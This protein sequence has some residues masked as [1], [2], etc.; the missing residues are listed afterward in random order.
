MILKGTIPCEICSAEMVEKTSGRGYV[1][2][3]CKRGCSSYRTMD[4][5]TGLL[6]ATKKA[7]QTAEILPIRP[8]VE[9]TLML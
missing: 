9:Y 3:G 8:E 4:L 2:L 1:V 7:A 5:E 6:L